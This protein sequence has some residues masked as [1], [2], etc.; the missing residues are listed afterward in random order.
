ML[1]MS[2]KQKIIYAVSSNQVLYLASEI[3][4]MFVY[5]LCSVSFN[6]IVTK[7][8]IQMHIFTAM[9]LIFFINI[10]YKCE[11]YAYQSVKCRKLVLRFCCRNTELSLITNECMPKMRFRE[12]KLKKETKDRGTYGSLNIIAAKYC[13]DGGK[14]FTSFVTFVTSKL[15]V[16]ILNKLSL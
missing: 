1:V 4:P 8:S 7:G 3:I 6:I 11:C 16:Y 14:E 12:G 2:F 15:K 5:N 10:A 13:S 9:G